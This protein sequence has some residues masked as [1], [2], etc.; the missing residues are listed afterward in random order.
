MSERILVTGGAGFIGYHI[1]RRLLAKGKKLRVIDNLSTGLDDRIQ[2]L[3]GSIDFVRGDLADP[4]LANEA[5][6]GMDYVIHQAAV[7][8][9]QRSIED[10][11]GTNRANVTATLNL[12]ESCR[13]HKIRRFVYAASSS[14]Y[15]ETEVLPKR[16]DMTPRPRSPYA[17]QK[18]VG[19]NYCK[20][21]QSL[22]GLETVSLRYFNVFGPFQDPQSE[23][24]AVVPMFVTRLLAGQPLLVYGDGE[25]TRDFTYVENVVEANLLALEAKN[26]AG[27]VFNIGCGTHISLNQL[28]RSLEEILDTKAVV[29]YLA[30]RPGDVRHSLADITC[31]RKVLGYEPKTTVKEG[32]KRTV[33]WFRHHIT[34]NLSSPGQG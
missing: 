15:G 1:V 11:V 20:L 33:D 17:L 27:K 30:A 8:S 12:L 9:V 16:E 14:A 7:P 23:Y 25:Q 3:R 32:L 2:P 21:Y 4:V 28:I 22:F 24:A 19:E 18:L 6:Q 5:V 13:N 10:P 34:D 29:N 31:A 26:A